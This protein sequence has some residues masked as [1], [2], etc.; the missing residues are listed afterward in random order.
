M[1]KEL[2]KK[3][4][5]GAWQ[6]MW[7]IHQQLNKDDGNNKFP[8]KKKGKVT[9]VNHWGSGSESSPSSTEY[10]PVS[11]WSS[12]RPVPL[13]WSQV[14][15]MVCLGGLIMGSYRRDLVI[16]FFIST[17][18]IYGKNRQARQAVVW[19]KDLKVGL[20]SEMSRTVKV[21]V[22]SLSHAR[23]LATPWTVAY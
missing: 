5:G 4:E 16:L 7:T 14:S 6:G 21:K 8:L 18:L 19:L 2:R 13:S 22:R 20:R 23:L 10:R 3:A 11:S 1:R 12:S 9:S 17:S 15:H